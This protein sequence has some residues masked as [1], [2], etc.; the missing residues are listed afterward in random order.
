MTGEQYVDLYSYKLTPTER[1]Y[2]DMWAKWKRFKVPPWRFFN[3]KKMT[4]DT[5][6]ALEQI[7]NMY[8]ERTRIKEHKDKVAADQM[9][10]RPFQNNQPQQNS[11]SNKVQSVL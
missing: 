8:N 10:F 9:A 2:Y 11:R 3:A 4:R 6:Q 5:I 7:D 1:K